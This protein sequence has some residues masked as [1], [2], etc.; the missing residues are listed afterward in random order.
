[1]TLYEIN[2]DLELCIEDIFR[3]SEETGEVSEESME[4]LAELKMLKD[5]KLEGCGCYIKNLNAE[6]AALKAEEKALETRRK[7][8]EHRLDSMKSY[9]A[10]MLGG[11]KWDSAKVSFS[12][13][14]SESV[15]IDD[16][17]KLDPKYIKTK[18]ETSADK[19]AI[20]NALKAG[21]KIEGCHLEKNSNLQIK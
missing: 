16:M 21:E 9:V 2:K 7:A 17:S 12:F 10:S 14:S 5:E 13:R 1:M 15:S 6:I 11:E 20:K 19:T 4:R 8:K 18:I 3:E